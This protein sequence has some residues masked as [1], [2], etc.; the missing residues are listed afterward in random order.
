VA[1][2]TAGAT[3]TQ[4]VPGAQPQ[5]GASQAQAA[6][7]QSSQAGGADN[8]SGTDVATLQKQ[9]A[10]AVKAERAVRADRQKLID[11]AKAAEDAKLPEQERLQR[12][13]AEL[14]AA[15][16]E[17]ERERSEWTTQAAVTKTAM[18]LGYQDP[19]DAYSLLDRAA[20]D[21]DENGVP[22]NLDKLLADLLRAKPYL[23]G[24]GRPSGSADGGYV[25]GNQ[26]NTQDM[27][28]RIRA[29]AGRG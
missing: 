9:L 17:H 20:V 12:R 18:R 25:G 10:E 3:G 27:N 14:E 13:L 1:D 23:G 24:A 8:G 16:V 29:A 5:A 2:E 21:R 4:A 15:H 7:A 28:A 22:R 11:A 6:D 19:A 26:S